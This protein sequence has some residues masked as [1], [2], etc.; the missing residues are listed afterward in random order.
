MHP[1]STIVTQIEGLVRIPAPRPNQ[2]LVA[3]ATMG[4]AFYSREL[5]KEIGAYENKAGYAT[6]SVGVGYGPVALTIGFGARIE[7]RLRPTSGLLT[8]I[9]WMHTLAAHGFV[10]EAIGIRL[11]YLGPRW[12]LVGVD[13]GI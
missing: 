1:A 13:V 4:M 10:T 2:F 7:K 12:L 3:G 8:S 9:S 11:E 5:Q 6:V